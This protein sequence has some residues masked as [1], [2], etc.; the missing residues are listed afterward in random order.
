MHSRLL[1][2]YLNFSLDA[3]KVYRVMIGNPRNLS[4]TSVSIWVESALVILAK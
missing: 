3:E 4:S 1:E 2:F